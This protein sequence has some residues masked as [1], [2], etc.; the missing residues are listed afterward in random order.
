MLLCPECGLKVDESELQRESKYLP[1]FG[2]TGKPFDTQTSANRDHIT[3]SDYGQQAFVMGDTEAQDLEGTTLRGM[4]KAMNQGIDI[5]GKASP[6]DV[7]AI[8]SVIEP[9]LKDGKDVK[10]HL[11]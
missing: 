7:E 1:D 10:V 5:K 6:K 4:A 3:P 8:K 9:L 11:K 2:Q